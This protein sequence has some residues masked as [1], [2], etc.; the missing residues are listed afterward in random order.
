MINPLPI[1]PLSGDVLNGNS[2]FNLDLKGGGG[3]LNQSSTQGD[4]RSAVAPTKN[5]YNANDVPRVFTNSE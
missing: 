4:G 1:H 3:L 5:L 2:R